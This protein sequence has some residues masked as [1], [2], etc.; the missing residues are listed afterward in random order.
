MAL[1]GQSWE[2]LL[3]DKHQSGLAADEIVF[4]TGFHQMTKW[5]DRF[6]SVTIPIKNS[7]Q[8]KQPVSF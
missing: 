8:S 6:Q 1:E 3:Q 5:E 4:K 7:N 2:I